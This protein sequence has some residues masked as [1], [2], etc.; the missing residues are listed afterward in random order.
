MTEQ[1]DKDLKLDRSGAE[2]NV[3][4]RGSRLINLSLRRKL[5]KR[6]P[7][8][9]ATRILMLQGPVGPFFRKAQALLNDSGF[10]AW[11]VCFNAGDRLF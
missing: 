1:H 7:S 9:S 8:K 11:R 4:A 5:S 6:F 10:D 2:G 3:P